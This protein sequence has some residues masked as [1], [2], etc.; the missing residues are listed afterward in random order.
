MLKVMGIIL[1]SPLLLAAI[2]LGLSIVIGTVKGIIQ[3]LKK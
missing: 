3:N 2:A 1:V